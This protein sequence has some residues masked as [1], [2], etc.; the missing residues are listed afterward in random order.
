[1]VAERSVSVI[2]N[3]CVV[4]VLCFHLGD[5]RASRER[6][7]KCGGERMASGDGQFDLRALQ[8]VGDFTNDRAEWKRWS[9]VC[10]RIRGCCIAASTGADDKSH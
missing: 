9:F 7:F 3:C 5:E 2:W 6:E 1:M 10:P 8:R 4:A